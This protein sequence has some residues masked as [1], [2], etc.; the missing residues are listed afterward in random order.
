MFVKYFEIIQYIKMAY[1]RGEIVR[2]S[3]PPDEPQKDSE[4][5]ARFIICMYYYI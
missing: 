1:S 5:S 3:K 4:V 2:G